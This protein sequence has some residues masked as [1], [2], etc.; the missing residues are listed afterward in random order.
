MDEDRT[1]WPLIIGI[2]AGIMGGIIVG[3]YL[4]AVHTHEES[5]MKIR[6]AAEIIAQ[7]NEKIKEIEAG[8]KTLKQPAAA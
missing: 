1:S 8:I 6:D 7:C 3:I 5:G 2:T 4:H